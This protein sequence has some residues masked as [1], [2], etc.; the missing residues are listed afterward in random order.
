MDRTCFTPNCYWHCVSYVLCKSLQRCQMVLYYSLCSSWLLSPFV[1]RNRG[2]NIFMQTL[3][4]MHDYQGK[5]RTFYKLFS[6]SLSRLYYV[7]IYKNVMFVLIN[8]EFNHHCII[9]S[10]SFFCFWFKRIPCTWYYPHYI[11]SW[12]PFNEK[13]TIIKEYTIICIMKYI[14]TKCCTY[15]FTF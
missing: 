4:T 5:D 2:I 13:S 7:L 9:M 8:Q 12:A 15:L 14:R 6:W 10:T 11:E 1:W 3:H